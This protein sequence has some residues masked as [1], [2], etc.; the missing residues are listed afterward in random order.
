MFA[1]SYAF[2]KRKAPRFL[3]PYKAHAAPILPHL[4]PA[5]NTVGDQEQGKRSSQRNEPPSALPAVSNVLE[6]LDKAGV[7]PSKRS[8]WASRRGACLAL[9]FAAASLS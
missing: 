8:C 5:R 4:V 6:G 9:E 7:S 2:G 3:P 1:T